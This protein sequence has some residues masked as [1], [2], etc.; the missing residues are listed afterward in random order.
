M[1]DEDCENGLFVTNALGD[2]WAMYGDGQLFNA[3]SS[4]NLARVLQASQISL[5]E[6][7]EVFKTGNDKAP[8]L[9]EPLKWVCPLLLFE[10]HFYSFSGI[11]FVLRSPI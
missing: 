11:N 7:F 5:N 2:S 10:A 3:K 8:G 9:F 6:I 4:G 1:H